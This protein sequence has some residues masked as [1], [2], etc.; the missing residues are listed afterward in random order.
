MHR[1]TTSVRRSVTDRSK[2]NLVIFNIALNY[3]VENKHNQ[4]TITK[5]VYT[6]Y[7]YYYYVTTGLK[8]DT[9]KCETVNSASR[10]RLL[11]N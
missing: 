3:C 5:S 10:P 9:D 8:D 4:Y 1:I 6:C 7:Y 2:N 11:I